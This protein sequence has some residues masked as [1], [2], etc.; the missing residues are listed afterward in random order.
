MC[1]SAH[2]RMA[3]R[4][5]ASDCPSGVREYSTADGGIKH[6]AGNDAITLETAQRLCQHFLRDPF[7]R[8]TQFTE[9]VRTFCQQANHEGRPLVGNPVQRLP[10]RTTCLIHVVLEIADL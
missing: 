9:S 1:S 6:L 4:G 5:A 8:S 2:S 7:N 10:R 3:D